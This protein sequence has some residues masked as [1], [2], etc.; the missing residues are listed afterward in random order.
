MMR[1]EKGKRRG[2]AR[3]VLED[4]DFAVFNIG[5]SDSLSVDFPNRER[6]SKDFESLFPVAFLWV[7]LLKRAT[8]LEV[9]IVGLRRSF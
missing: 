4:A 6:R 2:K 5:N 7:D 8:T 1:L 9:K 3:Q